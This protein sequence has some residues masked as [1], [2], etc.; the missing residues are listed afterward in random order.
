MKSEMQTHKEF[1]DSDPRP[2]MFIEARR[3]HDGE[4]CECFGAPVG[5]WTDGK[6]GNGYETL[7]CLS[8]LA[9]SLHRLARQLAEQA[10]IS[11]D[12]AS[13]ILD[14]LSTIVLYGA[15]GNGGKRRERKS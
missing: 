5:A 3:V 14:T 8:A 4:G 12:G 11:P 9:S 13:S 2:G 15:D 10:M 6:D 7:M 1:L